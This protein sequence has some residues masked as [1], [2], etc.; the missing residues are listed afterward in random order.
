MHIAHVQNTAS[1][2]AAQPQEHAQYIQARR[3][4]RKQQGRG[5]KENERGDRLATDRQAERERYL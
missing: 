3:K 1:Q 2:Q 5:G 4:A